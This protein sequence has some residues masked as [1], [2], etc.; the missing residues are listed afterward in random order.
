LSVEP[1]ALAEDCRMA[2]VVVTALD[3][4]EG[5][6]AMVIDG[7][8]LARRGVHALFLEGGAGEP[9][10]FRVTTARPE[11]RRPWMPPLPDRVLG[12]G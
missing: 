8:D 11:A 3:A 9:P 7:R 10:A 2:F 1:S 4:P 12:E 6:A 5:C